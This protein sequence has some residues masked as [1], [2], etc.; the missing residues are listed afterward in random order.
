MICSFARFLLR[1]ASYR[2]RGTR[3]SLFFYEWT[4]PWTFHVGAP[5]EGPLSPVGHPGRTGCCGP[6]LARFL[7]ALDLD[8]LSRFQQRLGDQHYPFVPPIICLPW[9]IL[10]LMSSYPSTMTCFLVL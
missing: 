1:N 8:R 4:E 2:P 10:G 9:P 6:F 3:E 7:Y 5:R